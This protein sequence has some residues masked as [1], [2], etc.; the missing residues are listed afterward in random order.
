MEQ[1]TE[2]PP[3]RV[4]RDDALM[5]TAWVWAGRGTCNRLQVGCVIS[6][7]GRILAQGYNGAPS[8]L[9]HCHH[10]VTD[11]PPCTQAEHAERNAIAWAAR[12]GVRLQGSELHCTDG[13]CLAC[14]MA[15]INAG[16]VR[17][18]FQRPYR[19]TSGQELLTRAGLDVSIYS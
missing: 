16:I 19:D 10:R 8:G 3:M 14:A 2:H 12:M 17:V 15:I 18:T 1:P 7:Q 11:S 13:P 6:I 5:Q 4:S 9:P